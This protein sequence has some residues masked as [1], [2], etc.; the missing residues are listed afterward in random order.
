[1]QNTLSLHEKILLPALRDEEGA[2]ASGMVVVLGNNRYSSNDN[3]SFFG[4]SLE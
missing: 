2:I 1:M 3:F 4:D